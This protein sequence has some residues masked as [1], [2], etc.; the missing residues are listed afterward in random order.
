MARARS[1]FA[2]RFRRGSGARSGG[3]ELPAAVGPGEKNSRAH[4]VLLLK[5]KL[6]PVPCTFKISVFA[7]FI[8]L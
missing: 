2:G 4:R 5:S 3:G 7:S 8:S 1:R 6:D